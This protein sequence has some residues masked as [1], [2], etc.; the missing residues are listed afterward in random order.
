MHKDFDRPSKEDIPN[1]SYLLS[2]LG[3]LNIEISLKCWLSSQVKS[4]LQLC[5]PFSV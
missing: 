5:N 4:N 2:L 1:Q 3:Y